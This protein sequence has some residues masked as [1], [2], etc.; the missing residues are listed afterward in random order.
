MKIVFIARATLRTVI[1]GDTIQ[2]LQTAKHLDK[3]GISVDIKLTHEEVNYSKYDLLH[4]FNITRP[5]DI[6]Y[7]VV[8]S[9]KP[10]VISTIL[11]DYSSYDSHN[12]KG[13][14]GILMRFLSADNLEYVK[15]IARFL[16]GKDK[17]M[18]RSYLWTGQ[19]RCIKII[20]NKAA[21]LFSNSAMETRKIEER[22]HCSAR[23]VQVPNG[24]DP[25][26]FSFD[27]NVKKDN[28]LILCVARIEGIKNQVNLIKALN[29]TKYSLLIIGSPAPNQQTYYR[30][31]RNI[32]AS[33][34]RFIEFIEQP[35]LVSY[36]QR[37]KVHVLPSW[38]EACGLSSLEAAA[39]GCNIVITD[40]G[41]TREYYQNY[42]SYCDPGS[43]D[44]IFRA[45]EE[46]AQ[47]GTPAKLREK[48]LSTYTWPEAALQIARA[49]HHILHPNEYS[50]RNY[51]IKG[52][53]QPLRRL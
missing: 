53:S 24:V 30:E 40:K 29:N 38:F 2:I 31:C 49:Y 37:A 27:R 23:C 35:E 44:S 50:H 48:I 16:K 3:L 17:L 47:A 42:A 13:I 7:H 45:V 11:I 12:R 43:P 46:A 18:T 52:H 8:K 15:T 26:L 21:M 1:G 41:Y 6:L 19:N 9:G 10:F 25:E 4:F 51:R 22:Y 28:H 33:N 20:L 34:I 5:A 14:A 36:Y 39:M 32:A